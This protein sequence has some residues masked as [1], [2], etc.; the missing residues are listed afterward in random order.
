MKNKIKSFLNIGEF[1]SNDFS[2]LTDAIGITLLTLFF[3]GLALFCLVMYI[4]GF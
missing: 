2:T 3:V 1:Y 4:K